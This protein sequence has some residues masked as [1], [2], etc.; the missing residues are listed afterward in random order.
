M[1]V[2]KSSDSWLQPRQRR[3]LLPLEVERTTYNNNDNGNNNDNNDNDNVKQPSTAA[4]NVPLSLFLHILSCPPSE[5]K[6]LPT[7]CR[8]LT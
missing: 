1:Y 2:N 6:M 7:R 5:K 8:E 4:V 3:N